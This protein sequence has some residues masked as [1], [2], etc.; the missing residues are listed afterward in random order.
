MY[1]AR[2]N[3]RRSFCSGKSLIEN[4]YLYSQKAHSFMKTIPGIPGFPLPFCMNY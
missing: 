3:T 2:N 4:G 1:V